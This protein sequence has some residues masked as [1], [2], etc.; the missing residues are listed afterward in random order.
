MEQK[1]VHYDS[2]ELLST[3]LINTFGGRRLS[4]SIKTSTQNKCETSKLLE[5]FNP[6]FTSFMLLFSS[7]TIDLF[8]R[9]GPDELV[10]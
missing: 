7:L 9:A 1:K 2:Q 5:T 3:K 6:S 8:T 10:V 4:A